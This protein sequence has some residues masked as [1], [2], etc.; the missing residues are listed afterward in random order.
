M[1]RDAMQGYTFKATLVF[2]NWFDSTLTVT[3]KTKK[4]KKPKRT[5]NKPGKIGKNSGQRKSDKKKFQEIVARF[6]LLWVSMNYQ[7]LGFVSV[8]K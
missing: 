6:K 3:W 4:T 1:K 2:Q 7:T 5:K 8:M